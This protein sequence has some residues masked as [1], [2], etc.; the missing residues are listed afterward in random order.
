V[1]SIQRNSFLVESIRTEILSV[2]PLHADIQEFLK[3]QD[4]HSGYI[5]RS[6]V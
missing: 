6:C 3:Q 1:E 4:V 5:I 2:F